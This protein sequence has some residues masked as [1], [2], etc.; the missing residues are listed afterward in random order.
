MNRKRRIFFETQEVVQRTKRGYV[1]LEMDYF[2][3]Y[4][5]AFSHVA[6]LS[7]SCSK[8]FIL[9]VMGKVNE[10][11]SFIYSQQMF[12]E[13]NQDL[14][15]IQKPKQYV[16]ST[17][18][19][20]LRELSDAGIITRLSRGEYRVSPKLFWTG[21]TPKFKKYTDEEL[22]NVSNWINPQTTIQN[23]EYGKE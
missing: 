6:S 19:M 21:A 10:D 1:D 22:S 9:W 16:E 12:K 17:M 20:A 5:A 13:F 15:K 18:K 14:A 2:Q 11:N 4:S 23:T 7:S 3:F 8:D